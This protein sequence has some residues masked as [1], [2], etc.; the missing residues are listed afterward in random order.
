MLWV[1]LLSAP[2]PPRPAPCLETG[3]GLPRGSEPLPCDPSSKVWG[4]KGRE[5]SVFTSLKTEL[6]IVTSFLEGGN[7]SCLSPPAG[8][9]I[10]LLAEPEL[11]LNH[12]AEADEDSQ[13]LALRTV[14]TLERGLCPGLVPRPLPP[15]PPGPSTVPHQRRPGKW[16]CPKYSVGKSLAAVIFLQTVPFP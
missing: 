5:G 14:T 16:P 4:R 6:L 3:W 12:C 15:L 10:P 11:A 8:Q 2:Y 13:T 1:Q 7:H 9:E